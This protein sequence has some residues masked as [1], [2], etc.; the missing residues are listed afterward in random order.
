MNGA[1]RVPGRTFS[2][3]VEAIESSPISHELRSVQPAYSG[4]DAYESD[5]SSRSTSSSHAR[6]ASITR[7][8][9]E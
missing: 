2:L 3:L 9:S 7:W 6:W 5:D 1:L 4:T 8:A